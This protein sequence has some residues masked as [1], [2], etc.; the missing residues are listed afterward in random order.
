MIKKTEL[1][2][3]LLPF[4]DSAFGCRII[5]TADAYGFHEPFAQI[6]VQDDKAA[7]C[8]LDDAMVLAANPGADFD[9]IHDFI[10]ISGAQKLLCSGENGKHT[11]FQTERNGEI[12]GYLN[13]KTI[14]SPMGFELNPSLRELHALLCECE[15]ETFTVPEFEPFYLD[16]S[17]RIRHGTALAVSIRQNN[18]LIACAVCSAKT[19]NKA[20]LSAVACK[21]EWRKQGFGRAALGALASNLNQRE[22]YIFRAQGEN[23]AFYRSFGFLSHGT[24]AEQTID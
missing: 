21:P 24:F 9:E 18:V 20:I 6:W 12:M 7:L 1:P 16:L 22:L 4:A 8:K 19:Q 10:R 3:A 14:P 17:H 11:G 2:E 13:I 23:E 15:T 5:A